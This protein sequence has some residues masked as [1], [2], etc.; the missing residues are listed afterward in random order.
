MGE[1]PQL[2]GVKGSTDDLE[3]RKRKCNPNGEV[4]TQVKEAGDIRA[5]G[6]GCPK[7]SPENVLQKTVV[8]LSSE[9]VDINHVRS[10]CGGNTHFSLQDS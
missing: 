3:A 5:C 9:E 10:D 1:R 2:K 7:S 4:C 6:S 8:P